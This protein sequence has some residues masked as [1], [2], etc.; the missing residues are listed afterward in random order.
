VH[1][2]HPCDGEDRLPDA[3]QGVPLALEE[4]TD[5][6]ARARQAIADGV[7]GQRDVLANHGHQF[8]FQYD[9]TAVVPDGS[10]IIRSGIAEYRPT[11]RPGARAPHSWVTSRGD[12]ISTIDVLPRWFHPVHGSARPRMGDGSRNRSAGN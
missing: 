6:G 4:E 9:S 1:E 3:G 10:E 5:D 8:G 11:A 2:Q 7:S 12:K